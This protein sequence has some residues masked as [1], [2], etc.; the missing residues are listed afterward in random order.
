MTKIPAV[1]MLALI[2]SVLLVVGLVFWPALQ[3]PFLQDDFYFVALFH[4]PA[5]TAGGWLQAAFGVG[6]GLFYRP[7]GVAYLFALQA[8]A[9]DDARWFHA[10]ALLIHAANAVLVGRLLLALTGERVLSY[11]TAVIYA[12]AIAIHLD[13]LAWVVGIYDLGAGFF[14]L[15]AFWLFVERKIAA[16]GLVCLLGCLCKES[17]VVL[18]FILLGHE[19]LVQGPRRLWR[20]LRARHAEAMVFFLLMSLYAGLKLYLLAQAPPVA[21]SAYALAPGQGLDNSSRYGLWLMQAFY[22]AG[23]EGRDLSRLLLVIS[24]AYGLWAWCRGEEGRRITFLLV[25]LVL[26]L[27]PVLFLSHHAYRYYASLA[28]PPFIALMLYLARIGVRSV[29]QQQRVADGVLLL[30]TLMAVANSAQDARRIYAE[31]TVAQTF[32]DGSNMLI[33]S[34]SIMGAVRAGIDP[35][36]GSLQDGA[37]VY[38]DGLDLW[39][40]DADA[41]PVLDFG[42][43]QVRLRPLHPPPHGVFTTAQGWPIPPATP[44]INRHL[45]ADALI[46]GWNGERLVRL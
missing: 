11:A 8:L 25:W 40:F 34:A 38:I 22:P 32:Y 18:P 21:D 37:T 43:R 28:L 5:A 41:G 31:G 1:W 45:P 7:L 39:G 12:A 16:S 4:Q 30:M 20:E 42:S 27:L 10:A 6:H 35:Y 33:K 2:L 3:L 44:P 14:F 29:S 36:A 26:A 15:L 19:L 46:F 24:L 9:G 17:V 13:T 23:Y